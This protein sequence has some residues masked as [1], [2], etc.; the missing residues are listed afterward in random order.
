MTVKEIKKI[1]AYEAHLWLELHVA[2]YDLAV[3]NMG[4]DYFQFQEL[5]KQDA[6]YGQKLWAWGSVRDLRE[7]MGID[8]DLTHP[9]ADKAFE[10]S[11][12]VWELTSHN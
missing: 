9:D 7:A 8:R 4:T 1:Q 3:L 10:L 2:E 6:H 11:Q 5:L 12:K